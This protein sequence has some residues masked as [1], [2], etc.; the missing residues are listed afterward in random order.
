M[1]PSTSVLDTARRTIPGT[2]FVIDDDTP[3]RRFYFGLP[4]PPPRCSIPDDLAERIAGLDPL[5]TD[6]AMPLWDAEGLYTATVCFGANGT[7][8]F[9]DEVRDPSAAVV[10][11]ILECRDEYGGLVDLAA[12]RPDAGKLALLRG[13][14]FALGQ[15]QVL[16]PRG[17]EPLRVFATVLAWLRSGRDGLVIL[18]F[19]QAA[20]ALHSHAIRTGRDIGFAQ[21]LR[22]KLTIA[23]QIFVGDDE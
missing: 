4:E 17:D 5:L 7:F 15:D 18:D 8:D 11:V 3:D 1:T 16:S 10:A 13:R 20:L 14:V 19:R 2:F 22:T 9:P 12:W 6:D 21:K 23:P